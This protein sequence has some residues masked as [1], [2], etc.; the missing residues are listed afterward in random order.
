MIRTLLALHSVGRGSSLFRNILPWL[1]ALT[2]IVLV[3]VVIVYYLRKSLHD[4][5]PGATQGFTLNDLRQLHAS[6]KLSDKEFEKA[7]TAMIES[8]NPLRSE[9]D[10]DNVKAK[11]GNDE[12]SPQNVK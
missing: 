12:N 1:I 6:G 8:I 4:D 9:N 10:V 5:Q 3:G 2:A 11:P 7:R